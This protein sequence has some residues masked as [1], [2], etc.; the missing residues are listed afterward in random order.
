MK[1]FIVVRTVEYEGD[2]IVK[3]FSSYNK[4]VAYADEE[5]KELEKDGLYPFMSID[6]REF[7]VTE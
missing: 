7:E 6:L 2:S 4:A 1:V 3:V 5:Q